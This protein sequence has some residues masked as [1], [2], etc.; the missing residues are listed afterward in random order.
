MAMLLTNTFRKAMNGSEP[1]ILTCIIT[2][3]A[4]DVGVK[5]E[6]SDDRRHKF[7]TTN[8]PLNHKPAYTN[9]H[10]KFISIGTCQPFKF[11]LN[12]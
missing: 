7:N 3:L 4:E 1:L 11:K 5:S 10:R 12:S 6:V 9:T 2:R 8:N